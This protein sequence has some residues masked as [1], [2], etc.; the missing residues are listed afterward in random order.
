MARWP[1]CRTGSA[2]PILA[3]ESDLNP[4]HP[5]PPAD[6]PPRLSATAT[7]DTIV[8]RILWLGPHAAP[9]ICL[10]I[11]ARRGV[12]APSIQGSEGHGR[13]HLAR[14]LS[15]PAARGACRAE[16]AGAA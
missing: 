12:A 1:A 11:A 14:G 15:F 10:V 16:P 9:E 13:G 2:R 5:T 6:C 4:C 3:I 7:R 8:R